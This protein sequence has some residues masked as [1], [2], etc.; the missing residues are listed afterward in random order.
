M[1]RAATKRARVVRVMV[2][3]M[4][5][6]CNKE[7]DGNGGKSDGDKGVVQQ[8]GWWRGQLEQWRQG[9]GASNS[10][11]NNVGDGNSNKAGS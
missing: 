9:W 3:Q 10:D 2:T 5:V 4:R 6:V 11:G 1:M 7:G 8:R